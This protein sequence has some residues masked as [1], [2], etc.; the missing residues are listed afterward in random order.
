MWNLQ[1]DLGCSWR[2]GPGFFILFLK[3][4]IKILCTAH[5]NGNFSFQNR[6]FITCIHYVPW[7]NQDAPETKNAPDNPYIMLYTIGIIS[8]A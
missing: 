6:V 5:R 3:C 4:C 7:M 2:I 8:S 1:I